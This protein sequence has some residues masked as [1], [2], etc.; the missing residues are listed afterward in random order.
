M[1]VSYFSHFCDKKKK[2]PLSKS[3]L[4]KGGFTLA[5]DSRERS[6]LWWRRHKDRH[7]GQLVTL[8]QQSGSRG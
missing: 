5:H 6:P 8:Q 1:Y 7:M 3:N 4:R 2:N